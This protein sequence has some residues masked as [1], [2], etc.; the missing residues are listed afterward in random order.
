MSP[1]RYA[2]HPANALTFASLVLG[3]GAVAAAL[4]G[5]ADATGALIAA[6]AVADIFDG[7]FARRFV[8]TP[9][10]AAFGAQLDSLCDAVVFAAVPIV[11]AAAFAHAASSIW[12]IPAAVYAG[13]GVTR[14]AAYNVEADDSG[15]VGVPMPVAAL[16]W[17]S[18]LLV[19]NHAA[20]S[21][22]P[23]ALLGAAMVLPI[24]IPRPAGARFAVFAVWPLA[25]TLLH[26]A[27]ALLR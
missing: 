12:W 8:R 14:L 16:V 23:F 18:L 19:S 22:W 4:I 21:A 20:V 2:L 5:H 13:C 25:V 24:R 7:R 6:A 9:S 1:A 26:A 17:S 10:E 3:V 27:R 15:F 11:C